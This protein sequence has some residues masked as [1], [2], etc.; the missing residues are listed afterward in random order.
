[1]DSA[2]SSRRSQTTRAANHL[3]QGMTVTQSGKRRE[4]R[5]QNY[6][7]SRRQKSSQGFDRGSF[8]RANYRFGV[9]VNSSNTAQEENGGLLEWE[10]VIIL[11]MTA[12]TMPHCPIS[13]EEVELPYIT[14]CGHVFSLVSVVTHM[15]CATSREYDDVMRGTSPCPLC[16]VDMSMKEIRP[17][18]I[19]VVDKEAGLDG[20]GAV[21]SFWLVGRR[22]NSSEVM[23]VHSCDAVDTGC[24]PVSMPR[25]CRT[26]VVENPL[27]LWLYI[28]RRLAEMS[29]CVRLEGGQ[30]AEYLLPGHLA[31]IQVVMGHCRIMCER[32]SHEMGWIEALEQCVAETMKASQQAEEDRQRMKH[33]DEEFPSLHVSHIESSSRKRDSKMNEKKTTNVIVRC[34]VPDHLLSQDMPRDDDEMVYLYQKSDG[35]W[36]FLNTLNMKILHRWKEGYQELPKSIQAHVLEVERYTQTEQMQKRLRVFSH[37]PVSATF[38]LCEVDLSDIIPADIMV[39]FQDELLKRKEKRILAEKQ[40]ARLEKRDRRKK[41]VES[42][43]LPF[44]IEDMPRLT[45]GS[46]DDDQAH[47]IFGDDTNTDAGQPGIN[48]AKIAELGFAATGPSLGGS[49]E[50]MPSTSPPL[51]HAPAW[52]S[53]SSGASTERL[54]TDPPLP[55]ISKPGSRKKKGTKQLLFST[56]QRQY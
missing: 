36:I 25:F 48:Y 32:T 23:P 7:Y 52:V 20:K 4:R 31:S 27:D 9:L 44:R 55:E 12:S 17:I 6:G 43:R 38:Y 3:L 40:R 51:G 8:L 56:S 42:E 1:M 19:R 14:P 45:G 41:T 49:G 11:E 21:E 46:D 28:V 2:S 30:E 53:I 35:Q 34:S 16:G 5:Q 15:L 39:E 33:L 10:D 24:Y 13:L 26:M 50:E 37:I 22:R 18:Q 47:H 29:E 54:Q